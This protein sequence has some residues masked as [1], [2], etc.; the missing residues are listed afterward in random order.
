[1]EPSVTTLMEDT[2]VLAV[3][4]GQE[5]TVTKVSLKK[6][7]NGVG[8]GYKKS[9][10]TFYSFLPLQFSEFQYLWFFCPAMFI[11]AKSLKRVF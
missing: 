6:K 11:V 2:I 10:L 5:R 9:L 1:M 8:I 7:T 3:R 4:G